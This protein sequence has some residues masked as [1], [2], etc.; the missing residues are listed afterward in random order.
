MI[1]AIQRGN[2]TL[3]PHGETLV[4]A[5]DHLFIIGKDQELQAHLHL[6]GLSPNRCGIC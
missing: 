1:A 3:I 5:E 4:E 6:L 2:K